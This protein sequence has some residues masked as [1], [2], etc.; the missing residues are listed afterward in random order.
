MLC[1]GGLPRALY[2]AC[3]TPALSASALADNA[4]RSDMCEGWFTARRH[5][6]QPL[7]F[8]PCKLPGSSRCGA[9]LQV[10]W[11]DAGCLCMP[12]A[13]LLTGC[14]RPGRLWFESKSS[15][16][17]R[18]QTGHDAVLVHTMCRRRRD[19]SST[20]ATAATILWCP[21]VRIRIWL[22]PPS[23]PVRVCIWRQ[24]PSHPCDAAADRHTRW[25]AAAAWCRCCAA[26]A[27][28]RGAQ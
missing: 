13:W 14:K 22:Q 5:A 15:R 24:H 1:V 16:R 26:A 11:E 3:C 10:V 19:H 6:M 12:P 2:S 27:V 17:H 20:A 25:R 4:A 21:H 9:D 18:V 8:M 28:V 23:R 7:Y